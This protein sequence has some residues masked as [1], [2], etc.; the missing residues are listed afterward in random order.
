[1]PKLNQADVARKLSRKAGLLAKHFHLVEETGARLIPVMIE[2]NANGDVGFVLYRKGHGNRISRTT[3]RI[4]DEWQAYQLTRFGHYGV[5]TVCERTG[6][7]ALR[8]LG[9]KVRSVEWTGPKPSAGE[10]PRGNAFRVNAA[11]SVAVQS[12]AGPEDPTSEE[13]C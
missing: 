3:K 4:Q 12:G 2:A 1:M 5:R 11:G 13:A 8:I 7:E 10:I 9:E 6:R